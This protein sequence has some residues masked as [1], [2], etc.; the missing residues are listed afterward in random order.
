MRT[1][2]IV[3]NSESVKH[4]LKVKHKPWIPLSMDAKKSVT[5]KEMFKAGNPKTWVKI[6]TPLPKL[7]DEEDEFVK[8]V[9]KG[10]KLR[11]M[12]LFQSSGDNSKLNKRVL[13]TVLLS[14]VVELT[15]TYMKFSKLNFSLLMTIIKQ[16]KVKLKVLELRSLQN[17][18]PFGSSYY[19]KDILNIK[20]TLNS[21]YLTLF[22][23][24]STFEK[25]SIS[26]TVSSKYSSLR[27]QYV[28]CFIYQNYDINYGFRLDIP[29][30][31]QQV[32]QKQQSFLE[33]KGFENF[34]NDWML[35]SK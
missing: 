8:N 26:S 35:A 33:Y 16:N 24:E 2:S 18:L 23:N 9:S 13:T 4:Y 19:L 15:F 17:S 3:T 21:F 31:F 29:S 27:E 32:T 34:R 22:D 7:E 6:V 14:R 28:L 5:M 20:S 11:V 10:Q 12:R 1:G 25:N 30:T